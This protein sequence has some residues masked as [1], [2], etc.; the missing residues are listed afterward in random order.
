MVMTPTESF[1]PVDGNPSTHFLYAADAAPPV[2]ETLAET[3]LTMA[4]VGDLLLKVLQLRGAA[5]GAELADTVRLPFMLLDDV[6]LALV[7]RRLVEVRGA[8]AVTRANYV[9]DLTAAGE[10]R[11][12]MELATSRYVGPAPVTLEHYSRLVMRQSVHDVHLPRQRVIDG[13]RDMVLAP[14][15]IDRLGPAINSARS[16]FLYGEAGNGKSMIAQTIAS[17]LGEP[18]YVPYAVL[19][20]GQVMLLYD[21]AYHLTPPPEH[22]EPG[23]TSIWRDA[24]HDARYIR[25]LRPVVSTGGELTLDQ[26]EMNF[27][28]ASR[29]YQAPAQV[30]ANGGVLILDD[31]GRQRV[32]SRDLLNRWMVPLEQRRELLALH[33]G[34]KFTVP[35]DCLLIFATNLDPSD[36]VEEAF[37]R[38]IRYKIHVPSP[39]P[40]QYEEIFRR[41][42]VRVAVPFSADAVRYIY[43]RFYER[44]GV[45]PRACHP[46]DILDHV[47]DVA[48]YLGLSRVLTADVIERA[49]ES[50][51]LS[52][53]LPSAS[54]VTTMELQ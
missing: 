54:T 10:E 18:I 53:E 34:T 50:Y 17:L 3:G 13:F 21:E 5:T 36:L 9:F 48:R 7:K 42:C 8:G 12:Q 24:E 14:E 52:S 49:C 31:F 15:F 43:Q 46:R 4:F 1:L 35:F 44:L 37:L 47:A 20:E 30:K 16:L 38:R 22:A 51:F 39:T 41:S 11:A 28:A 40:E 23:V 45:E 27:D 29:I 26:L 25:V 19:V 32:P 2:P 6:L 33:T